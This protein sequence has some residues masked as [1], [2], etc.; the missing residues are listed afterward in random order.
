MLVLSRRIGEEIVIGD[1]I[2]LSVV[3]IEG[4]KVRLGISA[5]ES[6]RVRRA[7]IPER[8]SAKPAW[9]ENLTAARP[10]VQGMLS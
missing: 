4:G 8:A 10:A 1:D 7:E 6:V 2:H 3:R 9:A 5:P